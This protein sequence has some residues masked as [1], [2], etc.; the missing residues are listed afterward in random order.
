MASRAMIVV[1]GGSSSRFG[2][3]KMLAEVSG[4]P[5]VAHT[6]A[7]IRPYVD[8][9]VLV[10]RRDQISLLD[11]LDLRVK[12]VS[13]G[14]TRT[15][16]ELAGLAALS[17]EPRLIGIH[18]GARPLVSP[19]LIEAL[20][21]AA[22]AVGG[23]VPVLEPP[24]PLVR[25]ADLTAVRNA[26]VVQT[27]QVFRRALLAEAYEQAAKTGFDGHDTVDVVRAFTTARI[28]TVQGEA[29]NIKVTYAEDLDTVGSRLGGSTST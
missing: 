9:C 21:D 10:V 19:E 13:G 7:A 24:A 16:S 2:G 12:I 15:A 28:A 29:D 20:F 27:P 23:A 26:R 25:R 18:D 8:H 3:D 14:A 22:A 1:A 5:L 11:E 17:S 4:A 6:I